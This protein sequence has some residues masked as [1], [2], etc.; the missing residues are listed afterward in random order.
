MWNA[1]YDQNICYDDY[2]LYD[3]TGGRKVDMLTIQITKNES[4]IIAGIPL[5]E[6]GSADII[7]S[8]TIVS[9]DVTI[10][11][12]FDTIAYPD[13]V[14]DYNVETG[15]VNIY[16]TAAETNVDRLSILFRDQTEPKEWE[17]ELIVIET[18]SA[19]EVTG[20]VD[21]RVIAIGNVSTSGFNTLDAFKS[22]Q[23]ALTT[24]RR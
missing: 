24:I 1:S 10:I 14:P 2:I 15:L 23:S 3:G 8:P 5:I 18:G 20:T 22:S 16:L 21:A 13:T 7:S 19:T 11:Y 9:G 12:A 17:D 4:I 6:R